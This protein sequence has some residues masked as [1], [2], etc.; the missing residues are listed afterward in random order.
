M[1][2]K[3]LQEFEIFFKRNNLILFDIFN[4]LKNKNIM[5]INNV[6]Y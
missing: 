4:I 1:Q 6:I 3:M 2:I 5:Q